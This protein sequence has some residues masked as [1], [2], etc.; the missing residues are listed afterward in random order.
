MKNSRRKAE[1]LINDW[2]EWAV[3][4]YIKPFPGSKRK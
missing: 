3:R 2:E 1:E 4:A